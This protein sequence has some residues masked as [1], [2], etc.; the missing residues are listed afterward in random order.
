MKR[1]SMPVAWRYIFNA[2]LAWFLCVGLLA[3]GV[4]AG[5]LQYHIATGDVTGVSDRA[6]PPVPDYA[7]ITLAEPIGEL[8]WPI[9]PGC[10]A[11]TSAWTRVADAA[12]VDI[13]GAGLLVKPELVFFSSISALYTHQCAVV[14]SAADVWAVVNAILDLSYAASTQ[15]PALD[16]LM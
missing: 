2:V 13:T 1:C 12:T 16:Q 3:L 8:V 15:L 10:G 11:G 4:E 6:V 9:P 5:N 14:S 7:V